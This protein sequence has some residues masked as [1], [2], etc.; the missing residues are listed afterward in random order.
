[1]QIVNAKDGYP[2]AAT[3]HGAASKRRVVI[4]PATG[5][6]RSYYER[7]AQYLERRGWPSITFDY[8][9]IGDSR[10]ESL[11][12]FEA[13]MMDW[14]EKDLAAVVDYAK[15][16]PEAQ[17]IMVVGHSFGGQAVGLLPNV[18]QVK[19]F[20]GVGAQ[21]GDYRLWPA[22][23]RYGMAAV[24]Y[25]LIPLTTAAMGYLPGKLGIGQDLPSGVALQ[26]ARWC[27]QDGYY[28]AG[29]RAPRRERLARLAAPVRLYSFDDDGYA[30]A[31]AVDALAELLANAK[32]ERRHLDAVRY[33]GK[34]GHFGFFRSRFESSLWPEVVS[35]FDGAERSR[36]PSEHEPSRPWSADFDATALDTFLYRR[37]LR[38]LS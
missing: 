10:P 23:E 19:A 6:P 7:F 34:I 3:I 36:D 37:D 13:T 11:R 31:R 2:L 12:G 35:F 17:Q 38:T 21:L 5:V 24:M 14:A 25:G 22:P 1:M 9:G 29:K 30:P 8:R 32:V 20:V 33:G 15:G 18:D 26:W 4:A 16:P 27:R 28:V